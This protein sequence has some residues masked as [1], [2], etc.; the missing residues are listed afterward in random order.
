[1]AQTVL[2]ATVLFAGVVLVVLLASGLFLQFFKM[3][4][5]ALAFALVGELVGILRII[6][7]NKLEVR[8]Q[9][10]AAKRRSSRAKP[11]GFSSPLPQPAVFVANANRL[12]LFDPSL[13]RKIA[14]VYTL[15]A[16]VTGGLP[17][18]AGDTEH[19]GAVL[20]QL[21]EA[22][23]LADEVLRKLKPML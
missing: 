12:E 6:E 16:G 8:L 22:L 13:A 18:I 23:G 2:A 9:E 5:R 17:G 3:R 4:R 7:T 19:A 11:K 21:Q 1:M 14:H 20:T 15:L 10:A